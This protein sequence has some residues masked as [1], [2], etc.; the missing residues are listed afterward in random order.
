MLLPFDELSW[1]PLVATRLLDRYPF[2][3]ECSVNVAPDESTMR[4][5]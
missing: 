2:F 4:P 5:S 1:V 3:Q